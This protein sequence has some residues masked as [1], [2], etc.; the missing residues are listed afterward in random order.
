MY[1]DEYGTFGSPYFLYNLEVGGG[2]CMAIKK[3][4]QTYMTNLT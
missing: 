1:E 3:N 4:Q 2:R